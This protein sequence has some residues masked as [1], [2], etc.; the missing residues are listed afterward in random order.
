MFRR[1][2]I[3]NRGEVGARV[4]RTCRR[5]GIEAVAAASESDQKLS[6]LAEADE[7]ARL[8]GP[9]RQAYLDPSALIDA[10]RAHRCAAIHPGWGF[11]SENARYAARC[12]SSRITFIGPPPAAMRVMGNKL[13]A[14]AQM[15]RFGVPVLPGSEGVV[16][17]AAQARLLADTIGYP[18]LLKA[19]SG[20]GGRGMRKVYNAA[21]LPDAF[22]QATA[23]ALSSF[24]DGALFMEKLVIGGRHI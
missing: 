12:A 14:R 3:G 1:I 23:E 11:L 21:E 5:L 4:L 16:A 6:W 15:S 2:L 22:S 24:G 9:P 7:V 20:G 10:A 13:S 19:R 8:P 18:V 17:D